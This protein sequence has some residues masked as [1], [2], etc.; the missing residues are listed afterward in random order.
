MGPGAAAHI[1]LVGQDVRRAS[2]AFREQRC[3]VGRVGVGPLWD[4]EV[5]GLWGMGLVGH[6]ACRLWAYRLWA[7]RL[8]ACRLWAIGYAL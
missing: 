8:W 3:R 6:G 2:L 7:C 1:S 4:M 5:M